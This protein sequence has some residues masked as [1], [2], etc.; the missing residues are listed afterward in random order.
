MAKE[1]GPKGIRTNLISLG[2]FETDMTD[3]NMDKTPLI[4]ILT[5]ISSC[6][7]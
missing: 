1:L 2:F 6:R 4:S 7:Y 5:F 3:G